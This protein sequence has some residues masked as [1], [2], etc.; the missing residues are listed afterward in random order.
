M[1]I[2][3]L[4]INYGGI[5]LFYLTIVIGIIVINN[6]SRILNKDISQNTGILLLQQ[7]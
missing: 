6:S 1:K 3:N 4:V 2:K 5:L 7:Q